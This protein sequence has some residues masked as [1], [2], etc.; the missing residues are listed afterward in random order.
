[1]QKGNSI[2]EVVVGATILSI[3]S[4]AFLGTFAVLARFHERDMYQIKGTLLAEEG[5]EA[6]RLIKGGG[7][8]NL[9]TIPAGQQRYLALAPSSWGV[10]TTPEVVDGVFYRSFTLYQV[11]RDSLDNIVPSGGSVDPNTL[12]VDV[13]T[14]WGFHGATSTAEYKEYMTNL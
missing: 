1:M 4:L 11:A 8:V 5:V 7:W 9:S 10:T 6:V 3:V 12:L 13:R 14:S 2:I